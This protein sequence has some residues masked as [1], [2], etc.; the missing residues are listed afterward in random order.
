VQARGRRFLAIR[1]TLAEHGS[2]R[3]ENLKDPHRRLVAICSIEAPLNIS[4]K[5]DRDCMA[6]VGRALQ[7]IVRILVRAFVASNPAAIV[8]L[9]QCPKYFIKIEADNPPVFAI[10]SAALPPT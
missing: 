6:M 2:K 10:H 3:I 5:F 1:S 4:L 7:N 9:R 8:E